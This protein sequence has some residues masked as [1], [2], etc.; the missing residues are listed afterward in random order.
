MVFQYGVLWDGG[1]KQGS[2]S[3]QA[4]EDRNLGCD[5]WEEGAACQSVC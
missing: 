5:W 1:G 4:E 3:L 2:G